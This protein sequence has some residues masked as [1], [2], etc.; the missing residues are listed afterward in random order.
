MEVGTVVELGEV[1]FGPPAGGGD[2]ARYRGKGKGGRVAGIQ[3]VERAQVADI[4]FFDLSNTANKLNHFFRDQPTAIDRDQ[5]QDLAG[6]LVSILATRRDEAGEDDLPRM[7][8][9]ALHVGKET[10]ARDYVET[11]LRMSPGNIHLLNLAQ[12]LGVA[13]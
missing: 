11:G 3:A 12:R 10:M 5:K 7:A 4:S 9:L 6:R 1:A 2:Q 13:S 8:W